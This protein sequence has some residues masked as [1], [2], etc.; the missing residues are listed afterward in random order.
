MPANMRKKYNA[1]LTKR[2]REPRL[3]SMP[4]LFKP[5]KHAERLRGVG[6]SSGNENRS[7]SMKYWEVTADKLSAA[8]SCVYFLSESLA[9]EAGHVDNAEVSIQRQDRARAENS[10]AACHHGDGQSVL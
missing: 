3:A 6:N 9:R 8:G 1:A 5:E 7:Y 2:C 4:S 10:R